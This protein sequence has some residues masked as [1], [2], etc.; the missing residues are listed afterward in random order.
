GPDLGG[1]RQRRGHRPGGDGGGRPGPA[2][3]PRGREAGA[4]ARRPRPRPD[5]SPGR[6]RGAGGR[7]DRGE[8]VGGRGVPGAE[9]PV[10]RRRARPPWP[11][12]RPAGG[13]A[14]DRLAGRPGGNIPGPRTG[15]LPDRNPWQGEEGAAMSSPASPPRGRRRRALLVLAVVG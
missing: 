8:T 14:A 6:L 15:S 7:G 4:L 12:Q 1:F 10:P 9:F 2:V 3:P 11:G 5:L 13:R